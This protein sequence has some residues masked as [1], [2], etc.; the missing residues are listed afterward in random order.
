MAPLLQSKLR[1]MFPTLATLNVGEI[2]TNLVA[3][4]AGGRD[5]SVVSFYRDTYLKSEDWKTLRLA[6]IHR[7]KGRCQICGLVSNHNDVHHVKY[8]HLYDV[9]AQDLRV[10]CRECHDKVHALLDKYPKMKQ[11]HRGKIWKITKDHILK[12][13]RIAKQLYKGDRGV[14]RRETKRKQAFSLFRNQLV[15]SARVYRRRMIW[16]DSLRD[17]ENIPKTADEYLEFYMLTTGCD[18][19]I[20]AITVEPQSSQCP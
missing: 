10:L 19:R 11:L 2:E 17:C 13:A 14:R 18:P 8:R 9:D 1:N 3:K 4:Y 12:D 5:T 16:H 20:I 15:I 6:K 7:Q